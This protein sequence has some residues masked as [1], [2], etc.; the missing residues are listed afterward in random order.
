MLIFK[1]MYT[2]LLK[3][4][5]A[6]ET[7]LEVLFNGNALGDS[8]ITRGYELYASLFLSFAINHII[9]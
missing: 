9:T 3:K 6:S 7:A 2:D 1:W 8:S 5:Y 4:G